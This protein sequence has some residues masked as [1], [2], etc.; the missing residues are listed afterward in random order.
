MAEDYSKRIIKKASK[1]EQE[2]KKEHEVKDGL[3]IALILAKKC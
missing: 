2:I 1:V 3:E